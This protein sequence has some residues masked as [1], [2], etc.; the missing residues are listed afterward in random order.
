MPYDLAHDERHTRLLYLPTGLDCVV[1]MEGWYWNALDWMV[2]N[3]EWSLRHFVDT[4]WLA[5]SRTEEAGVMS[6][7]E[8]KIA[9]FRDGL[10]CII[11]LHMDEILAAED[12]AASAA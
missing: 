12:A 3:S 9:E 11:S 10:K 7:P 8:N 1:A 6:N 4:A 2:E 5:A